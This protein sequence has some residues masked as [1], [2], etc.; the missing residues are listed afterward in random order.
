MC[1]LPRRH[2]LPNLSL[3][4]TSQVAVLSTL[5]P[6]P[7]LVSTHKKAQDLRQSVTQDS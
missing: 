3:A 1:P 7:S 5:V 6:A 2:V 4:A